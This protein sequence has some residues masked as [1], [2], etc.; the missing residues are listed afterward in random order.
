MIATVAVVVMTQDLA[1]GVLVGVLL[2]GVFFAW[3]VGRMLDVA[4]SLQ[5][6]VRVYTVTGQVFF[7]CADQFVRAFDIKEDVK[8]IRIDVSRAHFWDITAIGA[9]DKVVLKLRRAGI[10]VEVVG[11]NAPSAAMV[12]RFALHDKGGDV[13]ELPAH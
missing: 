11:L 2:S 10:D 13:R 6:G 12:E 9:L 3:K 1:R 8:R 5:G 7:A 4:S